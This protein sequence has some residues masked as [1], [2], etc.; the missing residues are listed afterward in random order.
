MTKFSYLTHVS[1]PNIINPFLGDVRL[2]VRYAIGEM[3]GH[4]LDDAHVEASVEKSRF[5]IER[6]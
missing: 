4:D 2:S 5:N 1:P 3:L 6:A